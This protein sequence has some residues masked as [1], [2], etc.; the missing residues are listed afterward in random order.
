MNQQLRGKRYI[1]YARCATVDGSASKLCEQV[2]RIREFG[3]TLGM[4]CVDEIRIAGV[5]GFSPALRPDL[6]E[7]LVRKGERDDF[8]VLIMEDVARLTRTGLEGAREIEA[9]FGRCGVQIVYLTEAMLAH[10]SAGKADSLNSSAE[11]GE[12]L[13]ESS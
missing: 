11:T 5:S 13:H 9:E 1:A 12:T 2:R 8:D 10:E 4:R 6:R 3:N 7:L